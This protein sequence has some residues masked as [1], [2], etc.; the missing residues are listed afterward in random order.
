[1][2][3]ER[4]WIVD[5]I[6]KF[7]EQLTAAKIVGQYKI[8]QFYVSIDPEVRCR[9]AVTLYGPDK[10]PYELSIKSNGDL[11][12]T[13][14]EQS[15]FSSFYEEAKLFVGL[16]PISKD[17]AIYNLDGYKLEVSTVENRFT[18]IEIEFDSEEQAM[19]YHLPFV[20]CVTEVTNNAE[21]KM[22]NYW[23]KTR[24]DK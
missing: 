8:D 24:L 15:I 16:P 1:M 6:E 13:E 14:I 2:E 18:Y 21:Y 22:K 11:S 4:K 5:D 20:D 9:K 17:Y 10:I 7:C 19:E 23:K 12:R 3:I